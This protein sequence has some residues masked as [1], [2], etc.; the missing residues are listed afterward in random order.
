MYMLC[1]VD[2]DAKVMNLS[3][4]QY[5]SLKIIFSVGNIVLR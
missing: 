3:Q 4:T 5:V 2:S 1:V